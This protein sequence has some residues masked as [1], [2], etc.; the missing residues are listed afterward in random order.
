VLVTIDTLRADH[1]G[2][3]GAEPTATPTLDALAARGARFET[4]ISPAPLTL[5]SHATLL[6]GLDPPR[7]G[8][9]ANGAYRLGPDWPTLAERLADEGLATAAFVSAFVLERRFGL[10]RGFEH[11]DD[12]LGV[13][14]DDVGVASRPAGATVDAAL[15][16]LEAAP[17]R[18]FLWLHLY[19]PHAPY[20]PPEP[21]RSRHFG[22][23]YDGEI[24][25][26]DAE[27]G[28][29]LE[30]IDARFP[31]G[32]TLVA[33]TS[34]HGES[35]G[36]HGEPTHAFGVYDAT[37]RVPLLLAGPGVPEGRVVTPLVR[38]ADLAPTLLALF[39]QPPLTE[40]PAE[41]PA[42]SAEHA[43]ESLLPLLH[44]EPEAPARVAWVE[45]LATQLD[46]GWSPL[47]GVR[48]EH[49]KYVRA[50]RPE[51]YDLV[52]DPNET[53]NV[54]SEQPARVAELDAL[55]A[56]RVADQRVAPNRGVEPETTD[57]L[58]AL[59]YLTSSAST[60]DAS[61]LGVVGGV[62][63]KD[64]M[65][66]LST[67]REAL[68]LLKRRRGP[69]AL[70]RFAELRSSGFEI[71]V[72]RGEAALLA[73]RPE[74]AREAAGRA[75]QL[76]AE[77]ASAIVLL[78]RV[79]ET[80][81]R[82]EEA[83]ALFQQALARDPQSGPALLGLGRLAETRG[84]LESAREYFERA[85]GL[86][87]VEAETLWR[88]AALA[89]ERGDAAE[90]RTILAELPQRFARSPDAAAR[91]ARAEQRAGRLDLARVRVKGSLQ[92]YPDAVELQALAAE[93]QDETERSGS[94]AP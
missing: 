49:H 86:R 73:G 91:L 33:V 6:T 90:A 92:A 60:R 39:G 59:G 74:V 37:Q 4:A 58:V 62:D 80:T 34:D 3:Y 66:E 9:R 76:D 30:A 18:F 51:L 52:R 55:V 81:G 50:P 35:L 64:R 7:H 45:T 41:S 20:E 94:P 13:Q 78:G 54:A 47:L 88:L 40:R 5:P 84:D 31:D 48:T 67:L 79:E 2:C 28:R 56:E 1:V 71:E 16:W 87:R 42:S 32:R 72:L 43:G 70:A 44:H 77:R 46:V 69:E 8:V 57:H 65:G 63:P 85:R 12:A 26:A 23:P 11:Y 93:L 19:D 27:L 29:L 10:A 53:R 89:I 61:T 68:T 75:R 21:H 15:A 82:P 14:L 25:Y 36:E 24:A 83:I 17:A 22:R 38:L